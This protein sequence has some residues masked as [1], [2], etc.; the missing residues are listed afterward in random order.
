MPSFTLSALN[1][2][3]DPVNVGSQS[4]TINVSGT[5]VGTVRFERR[6][7]PDPNPEAGWAPIAL[8]MVG[9]FVQFTAPTGDIPGR[10]VEAEPVAQIRAFMFAYTSG[11]A[12]VRIGA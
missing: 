10:G 7:R 2:K 6:V 9:N 3:T 4:F 5:F 12:N 1:Q 11:A 8:D